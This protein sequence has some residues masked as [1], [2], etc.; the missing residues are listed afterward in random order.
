M[1]DKSVRFTNVPDNVAL[2]RGFDLGGASP[3]P[4]LLCLA[5]KG[6]KRRPETRVRPCRPDA[7]CFSKTGAA[8][9]LR[10]LR[11]RLEHAGRKAPV[12]CDARRALRGDKAAKRNALCRPIWRFDI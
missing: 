9:D 7:L 5:K 8:E 11:R 6:E 10:Q 2:T 1:E 4:T 3:D 12:F